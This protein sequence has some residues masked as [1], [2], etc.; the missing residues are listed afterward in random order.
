MMWCCGLRPRIPPVTRLCGTRRPGPLMLGERGIGGAAFGPVGLR[1]SDSIVPPYGP[2][3]R[4]SPQIKAQLTEPRVLPPRAAEDHRRGPHRGCAV[5]SSRFRAVAQGAAPTSRRPR[6]P[7]SRKVARRAATP[8]CGRDHRRCGTS[9]SSKPSSLQ[10]PVPPRRST[11]ESG[12]RGHSGRGR[13]QP[14]RH[15]SFGYA[16]IRARGAAASRSPA[17]N[18]FRSLGRS[19]PRERERAGQRPARAAT[20][21][22]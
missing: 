11:A 10:R 21:L 13:S 2:N 5:G 20:E 16:A 6:Q 9:A 22:P 3:E 12:R 7:S 4:M 15:H 19:R 1:G 18:T 17:P 8:P 14:R